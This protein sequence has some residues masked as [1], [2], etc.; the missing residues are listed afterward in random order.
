MKI[1]RF[2]YEGSA[3]FGLLRQG[4]VTPLSEKNI[5]QGSFDIRAETLP[6]SKIRLLAPSVPSKIVAVGLNY[7]DHAKELKMAVPANPVLFI[8]PSS[9][10]L[11]PGG[12]IVWP[13]SVGRLDYEAELAFVIGKTCRNIPA[14]RA[15]EFI[16]GYTC[17]NDVTARDQQ[18]KDI[19]WTRAKSYDTFSP[20]GPWIVTADELDPDNLKIQA[21][22]N[23]EIRQN[24][25]TSLFI[26]KVRQLLEFISSVM[27]LFPG[28]VVT[29][30]TPPGV[31]PVRKGDFV[32]IRIEKIG[33]LTNRIV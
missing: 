28:D 22:V 5:F 13:P 1:I 15:D 25:S 29:T 9:S 21:L 6:L 17:F 19:Q 8:K 14:A 24:S 16:L 26:F 12:D 3:S 7:I 30:G 2:E 10:V 18:E 33:E 11:D 23:G 20:F 27:T 32:T 4:T 31:G